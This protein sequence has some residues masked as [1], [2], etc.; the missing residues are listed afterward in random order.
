MPEV[1]GDAL[2]LHQPAD[3]GE[4]AFAI[5]HHVAADGIVALKLELHVRPK[6]REHRLENVRDGLL[7]EDA[8]A[9]ALRPEP[10]RGPH[11]GLEVKIVR[12]L[13]PLDLHDLADDAMEMPLRAITGEMDDDGLA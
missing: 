2:L 13:A 3:E 9:H 1:V 6:L 8:A 7:L 11:L 10:E 5:L 4:I 12:V